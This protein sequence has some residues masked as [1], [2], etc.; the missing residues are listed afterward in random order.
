MKTNF[1][2]GKNVLESLTTGMYV[3]P[4]IIFREYI[5]NSADA[6]DDAVKQG[7]LGYKESYIKIFLNEE[8]A[9]LSIEDNGI[10]IM[11]EEALATLTSLGNSKKSPSQNKGFRG[12]GRLGGLSYCESLVFET[13][14][15]GQD[16]LTRV[17]LDA[18]KLRH[19]LIPGVYEEVNTLEEV[20][21]KI[22]QIEVLPA[23]RH[24]HYF[25]VTLNQVNSKLNLLD[26]DKIEKYIQ[27]VAPIPFDQKK[28]SFANEVY[29]KLLEHGVSIPNYN[30]YLGENEDSL[31][32]LFKPYKDKFHTDMSKKV[33][34]SFS[35]I[36]FSPIFDNCN[37]MVALVWY[38]QCS[39]YGT[40]LDENVKGLRVRKSDILIGDRTLLNS[41]Y[42]EERFNGWVQG[43]VIIVDKNIIPNA[44]RDD[45]EKNEAY[46]YLINKLR[47]ITDQIATDIR[48]ASKLRNVNVKAVNITE[49]KT[50]VGERNELLLARFDQIIDKLSSKN[51]N[52]IQQV[53]E[54]LINE[55]D[56]KQAEVIIGKV[57]RLI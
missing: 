36:N 30:I 55:M 44:R 45:F 51:Q 33:V 57:R 47:N 8:E 38:G 31:I 26:L 23:E 4:N 24:Q 35:G 43:E 27:Q 37:K 13:S 29:T 22:T 7:L 54:I 5:Q 49:Q 21:D 10:G 46:L 48:N 39:L 16:T 17:T 3:D 52:F 1:V 15:D 18:A 32:Q 14:Y 56:Q 41:L 40:V 50:K 25:K 28:L 53:Y 2:I 12:I 6:I 34:D 20:L 9:Q 19:I 42:K 11:Q